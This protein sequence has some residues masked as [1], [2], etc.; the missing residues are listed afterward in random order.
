MSR[1]PTRPIRIVH[2]MSTNTYT[3]VYNTYIYIYIHAHICIHVYIY[4]YIHNS[5]GALSRAVF[6]KM[7]RVMADDNTTNN[8]DNDQHSNTTSANTN[9]TTI[10]SNILHYMIS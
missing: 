9:T 1:P 3:S 8:N 2:I 10:Y 4:I 7:S 6:H 5:T